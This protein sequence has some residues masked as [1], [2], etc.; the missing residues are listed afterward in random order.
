MSFRIHRKGLVS[1][2]LF[3]TSDTSSTSSGAISATSFYTVDS[4]I[5]TFSIICFAGGGGRSGEGE[6]EGEGQV[7]RVK[8]N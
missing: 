6:E 4:T 3:D 7:E 8:T 1:I 5:T 2:L